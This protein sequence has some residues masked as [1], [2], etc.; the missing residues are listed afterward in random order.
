MD[1]A[2]ESLWKA[3]LSRAGEHDK[4]VVLAHDSVLEPEVE[5]YWID[6]N[7]FKASLKD[8]DDKIKSSLS[9]VLN[10]DID[11]KD[12]Q[13]NAL[14]SDFN[15][16]GV[17]VQARQLALDESLL[18]IALDK[19][20]H[21]EPLTDKEI[22]EIAKY[23]AQGGAPLIRESPVKPSLP[24]EPMAPMPGIWDTIP[25]YVK[26]GGAAVGLAIVANAIRR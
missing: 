11:V 7:R 15:N 2:G 9:V 17:R 4:A 6:W 26:L 3:T 20:K 22:G 19:Q 25:W 24:R 14:I 10:S 16:L 21:G 23:T 1:S 18:L 12:A 13:L 8:L 5:A